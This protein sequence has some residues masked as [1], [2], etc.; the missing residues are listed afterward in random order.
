MLASLRRVGVPRR[1]ED[2]KCERELKPQRPDKTIYNS[3]IKVARPL[4][5][6]HVMLRCGSRLTH[7]HTVRVAHDRHV[8]GC[9]PRGQR[10][11][12]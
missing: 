4:S 9:N 6:F 10:E 5:Q 2:A 1:S 3:C 7:D 11:T 12:R 8:D